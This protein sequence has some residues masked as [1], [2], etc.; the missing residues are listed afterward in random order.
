M[1]NFINKDGLNNYMGS[2]K[3]QLEKA[4]VKPIETLV[5][6]GYKIKIKTMTNFDHLYK[7]IVFWMKHH[8]YEWKE[9]TYGIIEFPKGG[10]RMEL[11]WR[12]IRKEDD[13]STYIIECHLASAT[14]D[15]KVKLDTGK[16]AKMK[17]GT[18]EFRIGATIEKNWQVWEGKPFAVQQAKLYEM[19]I[20]DKLENQKDE[21]MTL[22]NKFINNLKAILQY[23][24]EVEK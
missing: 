1:Q 15:V 17:S 18:H 12:G 9:L 13:Y 4:G 22:A 23:Y 14:S 16:E 8:G 11:L 19:L 5:P 2:F 3:S 20:R 21:A 6:F 7:E 10:E 24:P